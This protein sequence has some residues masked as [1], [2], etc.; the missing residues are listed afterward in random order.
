MVR[1]YERRSP[2]IEYSFLSQPPV[3]AQMAAEIET[4]DDEFSI[5]KS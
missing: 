3:I 4:F 2:G 5:L 1:T